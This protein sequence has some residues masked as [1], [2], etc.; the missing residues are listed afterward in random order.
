MLFPDLTVAENIFISHQ[1]RGLLTGWADMNRRAHAVVIIDAAGWHKPGGRL[2]MP[3]NISTL[4]LPPTPLRLPPQ[5][6]S[7]AGGPGSLRPS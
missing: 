7:Q 3:E 4:T 1:D 2:T 6:A 5:P